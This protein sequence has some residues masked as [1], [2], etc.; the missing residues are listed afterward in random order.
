M[1]YTAGDLLTGALSELRVARAGDALAPEDQTFALQVLN[2]LLDAWN[3]DGQTVYN[4]GF[5]TFTLTANLQPHT[6]GLSTNTPT[7]NVSVGRP[8]DLLAANL[9]LTNN[10]RVPFI[11]LNDTEWADIRAGA[12]AGQTATITSAV[13][14]RL[15]Y[16]PDWPN[17]SIYLW[18][19][20]TTAY[21]LELETK[22][23][24]ASLAATDTLSLPFG[25]QQAL[26]LTLAELLAAPFG[27]SLSPMT[28]QK[29]QEARARVFAN[30]VVTL[31]Q[32]TADAGVPQGGNR[33]RFNFLTGEIT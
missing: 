29:A 1:P 5:A 11:L 27:Q 25:Y 3:A 32:R 24:L 19:V 33:G 23:L 21:G 15:Y 18:P 30:T 22:T 20:P 6:I 28:V 26:R 12:A 16:S 4:V 14:R 17:G 9:V 8:V 10:I 2:E 31:N 13:P 7:F